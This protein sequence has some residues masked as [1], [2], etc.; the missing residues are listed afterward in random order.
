MSITMSAEIQSEKYI[1]PNG[2][3]KKDKFF[4][5]DG[6]PLKLKST[7]RAG[8]IILEE[9][10]LDSNVNVKF[11]GR[12]SSKGGLNHD[13]FNH[14]VAALFMKEIYPHEKITSFSHYGESFVQGFQGAVFQ[15]SNSLDN[16]EIYSELDLGGYLTFNCKD[17]L[18]VSLQEIEKIVEFYYSGYFTGK[19]YLSNQSLVK[20]RQDLQTARHDFNNTI[21]NM[22]PKDKDNQVNYE[23][24]YLNIPEMKFLDKDEIHFQVK[25]AMDKTK[26]VIQ[27]VFDSQYSQ[28]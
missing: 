22:L 26:Q 19:E 20:L 8:D 1:E 23:V 2:G 5:S 14:P 24:T 7:Y 15:E 25:N 18:P 6:T 9:K 4:E 11:E 10:N 21:N 13:M 16:N 27:S 28:N 17:I 3:V 12:Y